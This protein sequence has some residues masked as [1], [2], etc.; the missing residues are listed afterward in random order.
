MPRRP[1]LDPALQLDELVSYHQD[2]EA[3]LRLYFSPSAPAFTARFFGKRPD[4]VKSEL[5]SRLDESDKRSAFFALTSLEAMFRVD[6]AFRCNER[7][8]DPLSRY[9]RDVR[10]ERPDRVRLD[11]DI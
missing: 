1:A 4:E 2:I 6:F 3:S 7:K 10:K 8:K 5:N 11:E 9:F